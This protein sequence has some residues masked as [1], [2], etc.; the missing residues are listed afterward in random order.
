[1]SRDQVQL[2]K[3]RPWESVEEGAEEGPIGPGETGLV[4][5]ALQDGELVAWRQ[6]FDVLVDVAHQQQPYEREHAC[7]HQ[8]RQSQQHE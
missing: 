2:P 7:E 4:D 6:N 3:L 1:V 8:V 5:V